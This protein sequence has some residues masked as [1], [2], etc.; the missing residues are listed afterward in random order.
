MSGG[1]RRKN[2]IF[3]RRGAEE[4][5]DVSCILFNYYQLTKGRYDM[6]KPYKL[7]RPI[8]RLVRF[9]EKE[10]EYINEKI[11]NSPFKNFQNFSR[12]LLIQG[13]VNVYDYSDLNSLVREVN[14]VG[15]NINQIV[16]LA[17]QFHEISV[18]D[19]RELQT[20]L[21]E[22]QQLVTVTLKKEMAKERRG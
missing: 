16:K 13:E 18:E 21:S 20:T 7:K 22:L 14:K 5:I 15:T 10:N 17:N 11:A 9:N 2:V 4:M 8:Q 3:P 6:N 12:N 19:V 1:R